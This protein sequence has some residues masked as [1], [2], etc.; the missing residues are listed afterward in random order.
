[1]RHV[2][3]VVGEPDPESGMANSEPGRKRDSNQTSTRATHR[4][5]PCRN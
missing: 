1:L 4:L 5:P 2:A 3:R